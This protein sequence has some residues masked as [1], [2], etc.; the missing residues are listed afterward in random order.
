M[1]RFRLTAATALTA[2]LTTLVIP[3]TSASPAPEVSGQPETTGITASA[4]DPVPLPAGARGTKLITLVTGDKVYAEQA[5]DGR[6]QVR[7]APAV[8]SAPGYET[9]TI[10]KDVYVV[11][12]AAAALMNSGKVDAALFNISGLLRQGYDDAS[13]RQ[14]PLIATYD[15]NAP[16]AR[17]AA[18][19]G[20]TLARS[21]P[22][23][24]ASA[25][26]ADKA[27]TRSV[28]QALTAQ[29]GV[30]KLWLDARV[31][32]TLD[33]SVPYVRAPE[34]WRAGFDGTGTTVAVLDSGVDAEH[35][36]LAGTIDAQENFSDSPDVADHDGHGTHTSSTVLGR[37][38]ASGGRNKGVAPGARLL[39]GKVL[40][41]QGFGTL[42]GIVAGMEWAVAQDA[43][44]VSMS[45]GTDEPADCTDPMAEAMN[46]L[47]ASSDT[48]FVVAAGNLGGPKEMIGSP[49]CAASAL[50]VAATDL[51]ATTADFSGRGPVLGSHAVKPDIAAPGVGIT[52]ARAGGRGDSAYTDMNGTSMATPHVAGAAAI[53]KQQHPDW[54][55]ERLKATLQSTVRSASS[56]EV[57]EQG[58][59]ELDVANA[60]SAAVTGP[61]T[62]DLGTFAWPHTASETVTKPVTYTNHGDQPATLRFSVDARGDNGKPLP[63]TAFRLGKNRLTVPAGGTA[64]LP[65]TVVPSAKIDLGLY[66]AVSIRIVATS[67]DGSTVVTPVGFYLEPK[68]VDLTLRVLDRN[69]APATGFYTSLDVFDMDSIAAQRVTFAGGDRTLRLRAGTYSLAATIGT[70][71]EAGA[72]QSLTF[73]GN[74]ELTVTGD[75]TVTFD[76]RTATRSTVTTDRASTKVAGSLTYGRV[77]DGWVLANSRTF[78]GAVELYLGRTPMAKRGTFEVVEG[79]QL[80]SPQ[81][82]PAPYLYSLA[83]THEGRVD[84]PF[85]HRVRDNKLAS[86]TAAYHTPGK[87]YTYSEFTDVY[88][89]WSLVLIG[90]GERILRQAPGQL[91]HLVTAE[92]NTRVSQMLGHSDAMHWS[93]ATFVRSTPTAYKPGSRHRESWYEAG[94]RPGLARDPLTSTI[95][96]P[97]QRVGNEMWSNFPAWTDTQP[98][99][100]SWQ[101]FLDLGGTELFANGESLGRY[102]FYG[103][104]F[105]DVPAEAA[106]YELVY[107]MERWQRSGYSW[108]TPSSAQTRWRFRSEASGTAASLPLLFPDYDLEVDGND[109]APR[110]AAYDIGVSVESG[111]WYTPGAITEAKA[112]ASYDKGVTWT[113][114][115]VRMERGTPV[116]TV[117]NTPAATDGF[118]SLKVELTD[119]NGVGVT[120]TLTDFYGVR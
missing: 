77:V 118:V 103:Q 17:K 81:G 16:A 100:Y 10:G 71:T 58:A 109:R 114:A 86:I 107:D 55:G 120:Q 21:L 61:G 44:V 101:G 8:A 91:E 102:G 104:G 111:P 66:G 84:G 54:D 92:K 48:L 56:A 59:G 79:W 41:D 33:E 108:Q 34:A 43:D 47:S 90:T 5:A 60:T 105:W 50:T 22:S 68:H 2:L 46:R 26:H 115:P 69:G 31:R 110:V 27:Q 39:V 76:A 117:D 116:A 88:R 36:D 45:I 37:G 13:T 87:N 15:E 89:P 70:T 73:L 93:F 7:Y 75:L 67:N 11:P 35:P 95:R 29:A 96:T 28:W 38:T 82:S 42:S 85:A 119:A 97:A 3:T 62:T 24:E 106:D 53:L 32:S 6:L 99:H 72:L 98:G 30:E 49:G 80:A 83:F 19:R 52:A 74:P 63:A 57:Y 51:T 25:L 40:N 1:S 14:L 112:W 78:N 113:E 18:P 20:A 64:E 9:R 65:V 12:D 23:V 4:A 94:V